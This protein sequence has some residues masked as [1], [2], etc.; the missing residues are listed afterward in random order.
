MR[1]SLSCVHACEFERG[2]MYDA[3]RD[4]ICLGAPRRHNAR[5]GRTEA[6]KA[7]AEGTLLIEFKGGFG[8]L[9]DILVRLFK[10]LGENHIAV[11]PHRV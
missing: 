1:T 7:E 9:G 2:G 8:L 4:R 5:M 6:E 11:G 3:H 10:V